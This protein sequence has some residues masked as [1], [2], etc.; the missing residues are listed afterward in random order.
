VEVDSAPDGGALFRVR[1][2]AAAPPAPD[3]DPETEPAVP[4]A[5]TAAR[6]RA[7]RPPSPAGPPGGAGAESP[8]VAT[9][10]PASRGPVRNDDARRDPPTAPYGV[11]AVRPA[12]RVPPHR[13]VRSPQPGSTI[14]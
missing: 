11:P 8:T 4:T 1:L 5:R 2:P 3:P 13:P 7:G 14:R 12:P 9:P 10:V 6:Q